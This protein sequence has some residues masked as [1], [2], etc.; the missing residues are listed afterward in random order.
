M[1]RVNRSPNKWYFS[2]WVIRT[3]FALRLRTDWFEKASAGRG[4]TGISNESPDDLGRLRRVASRIPPALMFNAVANSRNSFPV[5]STPLT[6]TGMDSGNR[7]C[8][9]R[10]AAFLAAVDILPASPAHT[11]SQTL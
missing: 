2:P 4:A 7:W 6:K 11:D 8:F 1:G 9:L 3:N 10:S 5:S